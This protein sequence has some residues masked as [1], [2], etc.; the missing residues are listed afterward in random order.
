MR[1][2]AVKLFAKVQQKTLGTV[3]AIPLCALVQRATRGEGLAI[4]RL[5]GYVVVDVAQQYANDIVEKG[6]SGRRKQMPRFTQGAHD[7]VA[8]LILMPEGEKEKGISERER[9]MQSARVLRQLTVRTA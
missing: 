5:V 9:S 1:K 8:R 7:A 2:F 4:L 6:L 3:C